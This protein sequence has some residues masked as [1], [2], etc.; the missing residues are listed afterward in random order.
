MST[1]M[2]LTPEE[3]RKRKLRNW[4]TAGILLA[5]VVLVFAVTL[6]KLGSNIANRSL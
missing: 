4:A 2:Q 6:V 1:A 5:F 3:E